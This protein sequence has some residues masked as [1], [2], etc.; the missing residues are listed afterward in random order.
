MHM[1]CIMC[2]C[3]EKWQI[4]CKAYCQNVYGWIPNKP[5]ILFKFI[6]TD[7]KHIKMETTT[8][9]ELYRIKVPLKG[10]IQLNRTLKLFPVK[11][12]HDCSPYYAW[13]LCGIWQN[14]YN[15]II[16]NHSF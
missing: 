8:I 1:P 4:S 12:Y 3:G 13:N 9:L 7:S 6:L 10:Y 15:G 5:S 11:V 14:I 2:I 16:K